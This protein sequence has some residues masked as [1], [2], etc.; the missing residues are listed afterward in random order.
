MSAALLALAVLLPAWAWSPLVLD[1]P[2]LDGAL[3]SLAA[4]AAVLAIRP[5]RLLRGS[6]WWLAALALGLAPLLLA[7]DPPFWGGLADRAPLLAAL[8]LAAAAAARPAALERALPWMIAGV[9]LAAGYG[10]L[11]RLGLDPLRPRPRPKSP[12]PAPPAGPTHAPGLLLLALGA[13]AGR[14]PRRGRARR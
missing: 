2:R 14:P 10:L 5:A 6:G 4:L 13:A 12:P 9:F 7:P 1:D 3:L 11:Q 8:A